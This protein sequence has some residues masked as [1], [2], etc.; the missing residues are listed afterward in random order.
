MKKSLVAIAGAIAGAAMLVA[1]SPAMAHGR[2]G[3][4]VSV[5]VPV[6]PVYVAPPAPV[7]VP[8]PVVPVGPAVVVGGPVVGV[9]VPFYHGYYHGY[10]GY[11]GYRGWHR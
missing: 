11:H 5:G 8:P 9:G 4:A 2:F 7:Y 6:A 1:A 10:Y 3:F